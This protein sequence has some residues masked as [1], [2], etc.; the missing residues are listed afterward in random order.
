MR[1][2]LVSSALNTYKVGRFSLKVPFSN[3][4][5]LLYGTRESPGIFGPKFP[6]ASGSEEADTMDKVRPW[7]FFSANT[8]VA[9]SGSTPFTS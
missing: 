9:W 4:A 6:Y 1:H 8:I 2:N 7:K 5:R 3:C